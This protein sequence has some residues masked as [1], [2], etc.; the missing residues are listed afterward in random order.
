VGCRAPRQS[1]RRVDL[2]ISRLRLVR[3]QR[4]RSAPPD[5]DHG[6]ATAARELPPAR[7]AS[8]EL[9]EIHRKLRPSIPAYVLGGNVLNLLTAPVIYSLLLPP[10]HARFVR[11]A[12][13]IVVLPHLRDRTRA[14]PS[15]LR[16]RSSQARVSERNR[17]SEL[18]ILQLCQWLDSLQA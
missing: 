14:P 8:H 9:R 18:H 13:P 11:D 6:G 3:R 17:K 4:V 1:R 5:G 16:H 10:G 2:R 7:V 12:L 15:V